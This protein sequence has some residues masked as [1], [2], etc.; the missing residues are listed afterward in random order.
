MSNI[1]EA[2]DDLMNI[3]QELRDLKLLSLARRIER[4]VRYKMKRASGPRAEPHRR[5]M[6]PE[7]K[8]EI[9]EYHR[10]HP[11]EAQDKI[12]ERFNVNQGRVSEIIRGKR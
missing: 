3:A 6:T 9:L 11:K 10:S 7:L 8:K 4:I 5:P 1:P 2:C 12:A